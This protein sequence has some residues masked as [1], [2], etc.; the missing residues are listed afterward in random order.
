MACFR[1]PYCGQLHRIG[2]VEVEEGGRCACG[3]RF[4]VQGREEETATAA[5]PG[6]ESVRT[7]WV[8]GEDGS[9]SL[10]VIY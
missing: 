4:W 9:P 5:P 6:E 7:T 3:A 2:P 10:I 1:C 8:V